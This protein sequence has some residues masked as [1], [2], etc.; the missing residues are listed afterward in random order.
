MQDEYLV[1]VSHERFYNLSSAAAGIEFE[2]NLGRVFTYHPKLA[3]KQASEVVTVRAEPGQEIIALTI[4]RGVLI[5]TVQQTHS[6]EQASPLTSK[7]A[8]A[9]KDKSKKN[10]K[11][12]P[13][14]AIVRM[15]PK[16]ED[17]SSSNFIRVEHF[18]NEASATAKWKQQTQSWAKERAARAAIMVD[19]MSLAIVR[20]TAANTALAKNTMAECE[21]LATQ[22]GLLTGPDA[23][24]VSI[25]LTIA[26]LF[27]L[28]GGAD[29]RDDLLLF[30]L[31]QSLLA[32]SF[33][34]EMVSTS[35]LANMLTM[36][37]DSFDPTTAVRE[38]MPVRLSCEWVVGCRSSAETGGGGGGDPSESA[39]DVGDVRTAMIAAYMGVAGLGQLAYVVQVYFHHVACD[40]KNLKLRSKAFGHIVDLDQSYFDIKSAAEIKGAMNVHAISNLITWNIP[41]IVTLF[42][43][44]IMCA[45]YL[46]NINVELGL[47]CVAGML[48]LKFLV[49]DPL[50]KQERTIH[51]V[52]RKMGLMSDAIL[53]D[54]LGML[55]SIKLFSKEA[56]HSSEYFEANARK[57][58]VLSVMVVHRCVR[59]F[60]HEIP[61][62]A[63]FGGI[64]YRAL[65]IFYQTPLHPTPSAALSAADLTAFF[66]ITTQFHRLMHR[67]RWHV[68]RLVEEF[69][70]IDR[71][72]QLMQTT[73]A[74]VDGTVEAKPET[75]HGHIRFKNVTFA[76]PTRPGE[77]VVSGL[78]LEIRPHQITAIVG[79]SGAGKSTITK[80]LMRLYDPQQGEIEIDGVPLKDFKLESIHRQF[81]IVNQ[82]P[83]LF[84]ASLAENIAYGA[85]GSVSREDIRAAAKT[86]NCLDFITK[87]RAGFDTFAGSRGAK[88]SGGQ[89]QRIAIA[90]AA[91]RDPR[92]LVLDEATSSLDADNEH[93]VQEA[94]ER[95]CEGRTMVVIAHRLSTIRNADDIVCM[96]DGAVA[97]RGTHAELMAKRG[98][99]HNLISKQIIQEQAEQSAAMLDTQLDHREPAATPATGEGGSDSQVSAPVPPP[100]KLR[101]S[102]S[103]PRGA[104][105]RS[106]K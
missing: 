46:C 7:S 11:K 78:D 5:G 83:D 1:R 106:V 91:I 36:V 56:F 33:W 12:A 90:R 103:E 94:L 71:F 23:E 104:R 26:K 21:A 9:D 81:A 95:I 27:K 17:A 4:R 29:Q 85:S 67:I 68:E 20:R 75:T 72:M 51:K 66:L 45:Y 69:P 47:L 42:L 39:M 24:K 53:G 28:I 43:K 65:Q 60:L 57:R 2:T 100:L 63:I 102:V 96:R 62:I 70:D 86:A 6:V 61:R 55:T 48:A 97:E 89:K 52:R 18:S 35:I 40:A 99:Y 54:S 73:S 19:C 34:M 44:L 98:V 49:L 10:G 64:L 82:N 101:R 41:Y 79:D 76:Y 16:E 93:L 30:L 15:G 84:N 14:L 58:S 92:V 59:E 3:S 77:K 38:S 8:T 74:L 50:S 22:K 37:S 88:L 105:T 31:V 32:L 87:F 13:W 25:L 80:L